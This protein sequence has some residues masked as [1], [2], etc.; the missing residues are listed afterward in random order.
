VSLVF[1]ALFPSV[2]PSI[3]QERMRVTFSRKGGI[4]DDE[5]EEEEEEENEEERFCAYLCRV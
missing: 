4:A 5:K 1:P 2:K 3:D